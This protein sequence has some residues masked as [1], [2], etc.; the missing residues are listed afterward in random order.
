M[1][2]T[3][4]SCATTEKTAAHPGSSPRTL[5]RD[6]ARRGG[7]AYV[8]CC[9]RV[10]DLRIDLDGRIAEDE[11]IVA[12]GSD[13][14]CRRDEQKIAIGE[15]KFVVVPQRRGAYGCHL[16]SSQEYQLANISV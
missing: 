5:E 7:P 2:K 15:N 11:R 16:R 3:H 9:N 13:D 6:R 4:S 8:S 10:H 12:A 14:D 1:G